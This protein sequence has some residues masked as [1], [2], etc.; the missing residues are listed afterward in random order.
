MDFLNR[1][2]EPEGLKAWQDILNKCEP[3][4]DKCDRIE[5]SSAFFRSPEFQARGYFLYRFYSTSL[6][7][8]PRYAEFEQDMSSTSGFQTQAEQESNKALFAADFVTR[9]EFRDRYDRF[10][11]AADYVNAL[12]TTAGVTVSNRDALVAALQSGQITRAQV[13][14][15]ISESP[16]VS[17]KFYTES[18]VVMQYFGYLRRDPDILY[19]EWIRIMSQNGSAYRDMING[20]MNSVEYRGRFGR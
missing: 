4:D 2:P 13:L 11:G 1:E 5:V 18:F 16:E 17:Q 10:T 7:R 19:L 8:I 14:R 9:Q 20:F 12:L 3:G 6:G 15:A